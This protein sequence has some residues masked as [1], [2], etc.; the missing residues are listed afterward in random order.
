MAFHPHQ[1]NCLKHILILCPWIKAAACVLWWDFSKEINFGEEINF[2]GLRTATA[3]W[4]ENKSLQ[5][6]TEEEEAFQM[7]CQR[8]EVIIC[9][10]TFSVF[11]CRPVAYLLFWKGVVS[12]SIKCIVYVC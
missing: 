2:Q 8:E 6:E 5:G 12:Q 3:S 9:I 1:P 7:K 10:W 4:S 11:S